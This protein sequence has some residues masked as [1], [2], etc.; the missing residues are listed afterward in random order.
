MLSLGRDS[1]TE[2]NRCFNRPFL[3]GSSSKEGYTKSEILKRS[4]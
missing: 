2:R 1:Q 4:L 3:N